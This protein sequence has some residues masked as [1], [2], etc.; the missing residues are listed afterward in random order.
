MEATNSSI[1]DD[2]IPRIIFIASQPR[3]GSTMVQKLLGS[4]SAIA[5]CSEPWLMLPAT[6]GLGDDPVITKYGGELA[7]Q[8]LQTFI[9]QLPNGRA[10]YIKAL[11]RMY[12]YLYDQAACGAGKRVFL[13]KTPRYYRI[14]PQ[15]LEIFPECKLVILLRNPLAVLVSIIRTWAGLGPGLLAYWRADLLE[16]PGLLRNAIDSVHPQ[17]VTL[18]YEDLLSDT[19]PTARSL[20]NSLDLEFEESMLQFGGPDDSLWIF[21]DQGKI[22]ESTGV[23]ASQAEKWTEYLRE[24]MI[25]KA[26]RDYLNY[27]GEDLYSSLGYSWANARKSLDENRPGHVRSIFSYSL[28]TAIGSHQRLTIKQPLFRRAVEFFMKKSFIARNTG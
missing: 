21:G 20:C 12:G 15:L 26:C 8:G 27:L 19:V 28:S 17:I 5:T 18:R 13:D 2:A 16:A 9:E 1:A 11:R 22:Y 10:T 3:A 6:D 7:Q 25:W 23:D 4:H 14:V 24:A